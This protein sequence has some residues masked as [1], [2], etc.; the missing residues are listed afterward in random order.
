MRFLAEL[1]LDLYRWLI[2]PAIHL[3]AGAGSGCRFEPTCSEYARQS[4]RAH[5]P[6]RGGYLAAHRICRCHPFSSG[7]FDPVPP[8]DIALPER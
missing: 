3:F 2:S 5:G 7:G 4:I 1:L 8:C 6:F